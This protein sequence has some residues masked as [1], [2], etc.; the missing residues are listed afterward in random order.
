MVNQSTIM[1][2]NL[3]DYLKPSDEAI[4]ANDISDSNS[5]MATAS[6]ATPDANEYS[7]HINGNAPFDDNSLSNGYMDEYYVNG[8]TTALPPSSPL[9]ASA[10]PS[11]SFYPFN[12]SFQ[13]QYDYINDTPINGTANARMGGGY[14]S[15]ST[16]M[17][18]V[19]DFSTYFHNSNDSLGI[20]IGTTGPTL[21]V[22]GFDLTNCSLI[23]STCNDNVLGE[24]LVFLHTFWT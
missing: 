23:N 8:L 7:S 3:V 19:D 16:Y 12:Q 17:L 2:W 4:D 5:A 14:E 11:P 13:Y 15:G 22:T 18:L 9:A 6:M 21:N 20:G 10:S 24:F 1:T